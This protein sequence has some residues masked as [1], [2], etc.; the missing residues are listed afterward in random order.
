MFFVLLKH[1]KKRFGEKNYRIRL[2]YGDSSFAE[3][4][5]SFSL[6]LNSSELFYG[7]NCIE[8]LKFL[9]VFISNGL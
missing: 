4:L 7:T 5:T 1:S 3:L 9:F 6:V 8:I 2:I